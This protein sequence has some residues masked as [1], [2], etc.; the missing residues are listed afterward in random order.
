MSVYYDLGTHSRTITTKSEAAQRWFDRG[1]MW[2]YG[3]NHGEAVK[4]F[5]RAAD[6]D[7]ACIMAHWGIA[8]GVGCN[9]NKKWSVFTPE[10]VAKTMETARGAILAGY[11]YL[12]SVTPVEAALIQAVEKRFQRKGEHPEEVLEAW[13]GEYAAAMRAVYRRFPD[14]W[15]VV[16]LFAEALI[17]RT[18]WQLWDLPTRQASAGADTVEAIDVLER[19][20]AQVAATGVDPHPGLL[21]IYIHVMEM[22]PHPERAL[23]AADQ[24]RELVP[25][26]G[27]LKHMPSHI[28]I[29]CGDYYNAVRGNQRAIAVD[30]IYRDREGDLNEYTFYRNHNIHFK[31][32]AA[33]LLGQYRTA[34][35]AVSEMEALVHED[36]LRVESP[37]MADHLEGML[38]MRVHVLIRFGKWKEILEVPFP[39][40]RTLYCNTVAMLHYARAIAAATL[41]QFE[42]AEVERAAFQVAVA[43][44][45]DTR[46]IF[47]NTC[48]DI[49]KIAEAM[50]NGE[51]AYHRGNHDDAYAE[52]RR[53]VYLDDNLAYAEPWGWM[54]P[55]RH[56]LGA[57]LLEQGHVEEA[58]AVYRAD[59]GLDQSIYRPMQHPD[60]VWA[61]HGY[62]SCLQQQGKTAEATMMQGRL[63]QALARADVTITASC[64]CA[65]AGRNS[66]CGCDDC[67]R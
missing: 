10:N 61:L 15:D 1:L 60:N 48:I 7:P 11:R 32:Y 56:A 17:N 42:L 22:S 39:E 19:A 57:L 65:G 16:A 49:L 58:A 64:F 63:D 43:A 4:C 2:L 21:H 62:V 20:L 45:P 54:M 27:H 52:L 3:Y 28:D 38:S 36:L 35:E 25:D 67:C 8:Y 30:N 41:G 13:N 44:V 53:A 33:M 14:D 50:M 59:L 29:L 51:V 37:P 12:A 34:M 26:A 31:L 24:L 66:S 46:Y 9:Y 55:T 23:R 6:H 40:N 47:N 18:P 5:R